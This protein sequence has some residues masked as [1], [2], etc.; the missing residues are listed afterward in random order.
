MMIK[1]SEL[2]EIERLTR[3]EFDLDVDEQRRLKA[4]SAKE[5]AKVH[6]HAAI[7]S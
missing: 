4:I 2:P 7:Y 5:I 6:N 3:Q 1:N